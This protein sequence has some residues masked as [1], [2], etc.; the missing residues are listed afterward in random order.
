MKSFIQPLT[1]PKQSLTDI[2]TDIAPEDA[3]NS[4]TIRSIVK[5]F[6]KT[7]PEKTA[8]DYLAQLSCHFEEVAECTAAIGFPNQTL[9]KL[10]ET[11]RGTREALADIDYTGKVLPEG[12]RKELLDSLCDQIVT[13]IGVAY[14]ANLDIVGALAEVNYSNWSKFVNGEPI[15]DEHGKIIKG[16]NYKTPVLDGFVLEAPKWSKHKLEVG[17]KF[18]ARA[19]VEVVEVLCV[20]TYRTDTQRKLVTYRY[21]DYGDTFSAFEIDFCEN[22]EPF[23]E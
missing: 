19:G 22:F 3:G 8:R 6:E 1:Q 4:D 9:R 17:A 21:V 13:A 5:W 11:I 10:S 12:W 2:I 20:G 15:R 23:T 14:C 18:K 16:R 7:R